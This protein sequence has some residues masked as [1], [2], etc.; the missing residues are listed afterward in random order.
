M[1][2]RTAVLAALV[3]GCTAAGALVPAHAAQEPRRYLSGW[4][5]YWS[6]QTSTTSF[7]TNSDLFSDISPFWHD[8][9][10]D[11]SKVYIHDH[12][13]ST[14]MT[15][16]LASLRGKGVKILPSI[17]DGTGKG[18]MAATL[19]APAKR[20]A[21]IQDIVDLVLDRKSVV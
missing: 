21:H 10:W 6:T 7:T 9:R 16:A 14:A 3:A 4:L 18:R 15:A 11:G 19:D 13:T 8:A 12:L 20:A 2:R 17:T 5:P 1:T